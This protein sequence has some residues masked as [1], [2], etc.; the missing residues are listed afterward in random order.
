MSRERPYRLKLTPSA[1]EQREKLK[2]THPHKYKKL[3]RALRHLKSDPAYPGLG[4]HKWAT[5]KGKAPDGSDVWTAYIENKTPSA[6]R[7]FFFYDSRDPGLIY[8][9]SIESHS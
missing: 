7:L 3:Q 1:I 2:R 6:W 8:V 9:I 4:A 5:L